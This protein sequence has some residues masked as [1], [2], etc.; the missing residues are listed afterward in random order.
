M[1]IE[2]E[3]TFNYFND[4]SYLYVF[5][6]GHPTQRVITFLR[7]LSEFNPNLEYYHCGDIDWGGFNIYF[8]LVEK[9][10]IKFNLYNMDIQ[11]LITY[12]DYLKVLTNKD[13][14]NLLSLSEKEKV[15]SNSSINET[16]IY[17]LKNNCKL[18]QEA[19]S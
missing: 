8:D 4:P 18:E 17:M 10:G 1:T 12:N 9:T 6:K 19:I 7:L 13:R 16:I 15:K 5:S 14:A 11:T 3:T 2:N